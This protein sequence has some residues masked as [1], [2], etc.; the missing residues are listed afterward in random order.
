VSAI[1]KENIGWEQMEGVKVR[2]RLA[3]CRTHERP[4]SLS[5]G[6]HFPKIGELIEV[7]HGGR[8]VG[9]HV[10]STSSPICREGGVVTYL[11]YAVEPEQR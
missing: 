10:T 3:G 4:V 7:S 9:A 8:M 1:T 11:L 2:L 6:S 5:L